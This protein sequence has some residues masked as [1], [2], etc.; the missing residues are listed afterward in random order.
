MQANIATASRLV[1]NVN[2]FLKPLYCDA[3][4]D[5]NCKTFPISKQNLFAFSSVRLRINHQ[6]AVECA[7]QSD[8]S[9]I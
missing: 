4:C 5:I 7:M 3:G 9:S 2:G 6:R 8:A 1:K